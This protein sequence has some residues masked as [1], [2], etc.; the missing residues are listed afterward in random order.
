MAP[1]LFRKQETKTKNV[2]KLTKTEQA[3]ISKKGMAV[4][5]KVYE[6]WLL[7]RTFW[8]IEALAKQ[9]KLNQ[10]KIR[11][12]LSERHGKTKKNKYRS[13]VHDTISTVTGRSE[14]SFERSGGNYDDVRIE[15]P[16]WRIDENGCEIPGW[17]STDGDRPLPG[18]YYQTNYHAESERPERE[19][20]GTHL[21]NNPSTNRKMK[22]EKKERIVHAI[23]H[24]I[25]IKKVSQNKLAEQ[26][27]LSGGQLSNVM[28]GKWDRISD[29]WWNKLSNMFLP[30]DW[31]VYETV[32]FRAV[33]RI[34]SAMQ[35]T[36]ETASISEY[37][38]AGK[39][40]ALKA[41]AKQTSSCY[42]V[43][44][45]Q[46][47]TKKDLLREIQRTLG[48]Y[49]EGRIVEML[50]DVIDQLGKQEKP[51]LIIDEADKLNDQCLMILKV[52]YDR[53]EFQCGFIMAGTEVLRERIEKNS[54]RNKLGYR[55]LRRRFFTNHRRLFQFNPNEPTIRKEIEA[56]CE[57]QGIS[58][59]TQIAE[60][61]NKSSNYGDVRTKIRAFIRIN[62]RADEKPED[63]QTKLELE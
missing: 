9:F 7:S 54:R 44:A 8:T 30:N 3:I 43:Q 50:E 60:I 34:C 62:S 28:T 59:A 48:I 26:I 42:Y 40:V 45:N 2:R 12:F 18:L 51:I 46:L 13:R 16:E 52:I 17:Y 31:P 10:N 14:S 49:T 53:L 63:N 37:S 57:D 36:S 35:A 47:L 55:E 39:S 20:D 29:Q 4:K 38:G 25:E 58:D 5:Q 15:W 24:H 11:E 19:S 22:D 61:M 21:R 6:L 33:H 56:M 41:Y 1:P 27:G 32:N 23:V